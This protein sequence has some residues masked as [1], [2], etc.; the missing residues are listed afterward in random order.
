MPTQF[1]VASLE[2][3]RS[4]TKSV[5]LHIAVGEGGRE[6][7]LS[8]PAGLNHAYDL[9]RREKRIPYVNNS[10]PTTGNIGEIFSIPRILQEKAYQI[11]YI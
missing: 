11:Q 8:G 5:L 6:G 3:V 4:C 2:A 7:V 10:L 9:E 1:I